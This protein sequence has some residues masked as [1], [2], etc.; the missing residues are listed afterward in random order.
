MNMNR[1][2]L[3]GIP[4]LLSCTLGSA[5]EIRLGVLKTL[6]PDIPKASIGQLLDYFASNKYDMAPIYSPWHATN[7]TTRSYDQ[8]PILAA[9]DFGG[10]LFLRI[11]DWAA[12]MKAREPAT[13]PIQ[14]FMDL[15]DLLMKSPGY[16]NFFMAKRC[17]EIATY[18][19]A[20]AL[21]DTNCPLY[22]VTNQFARFDAAWKTP[23]G[24]AQMLN[25]DVGARLFDIP[26][27]D[28]K[29]QQQYLERLWRIGQLM[30]MKY[31]TPEM[32]ACFEGHPPAGMENVS[33]T[34][35]RW[36]LGAYETPFM[37]EHVLF[38]KDDGKVSA[39]NWNAND[40]ETLIVPYA[41]PQ[42]SRLKCLAEFRA[43]IGYF[44]GEFVPN[45]DSATSQQKAAFIQVWSDYRKQKGLP[46]DTGVAVTAWEVYRDIM[47][48]AFPE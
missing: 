32:Q 12:E 6:T 43:A 14:Q 45:E 7:I 30:V 37:R 1:W 19:I 31:S 25:D 40:H 44:P 35:R 33:E 38:F 24:R 2:F 36:Y 15:A 8:T 27:N 16:G 5:K 48:C 13:E 18:G 28:E 9:R 42:L 23:A 3:I 39:R 22:G 29:A 26:P 46:D 4:L 47:S 17:H 10:A 20:R 34:V 41:E 21:A 11:E